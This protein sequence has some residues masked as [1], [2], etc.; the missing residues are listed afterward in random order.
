MSEKMGPKEIELFKANIEK[1]IRTALSDSDP[2]HREVSWGIFAYATMLLY[3][4]NPDLY[5]REIGDSEDPEDAI[6]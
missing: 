1:R 4:M 2:F 3:S 5:Q 6:L